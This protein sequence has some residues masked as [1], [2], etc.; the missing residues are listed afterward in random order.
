MLSAISRPALKRKS[1]DD[2]LNMVF[3]LKWTCVLDFV[4]E[5]PDGGC[6]QSIG[7]ALGITRERARQLLEDRRYRGPGR[8]VVS[9][10]LR[11]SARRKAMLEPF[12]EGNPKLWE[13]YKKDA[14]LSKVHG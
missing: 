2:I 4:D 3:A 9:K 5:F 12:W 10:T 8:G 1:D 11:Q 14:V 13:G 6:L 7:D